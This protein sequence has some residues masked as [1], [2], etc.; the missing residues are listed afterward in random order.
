[1][2]IYLCKLGIGSLQVVFC[3]LECL[4]L[5][6]NSHNDVIVG[7]DVQQEVA[8]ASRCTRFFRHYVQILYMLQLKVRL[9]I[10]HVLIGHLAFIN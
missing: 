6:L 3:L 10:L 7:Y 9:G 4:A 2:C 1:M 8:K 5:G